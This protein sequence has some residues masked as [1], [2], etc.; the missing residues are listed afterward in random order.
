MCSVVCIGQRT[1]PFVR[2]DHNFVALTLK[3]EKDRSSLSLALPL[4]VV[5]N[6]L[7]LCS[8]VLDAE[9]GPGTS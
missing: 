5:G 4:M 9:M 8:L 6:V 2:K 1:E 3:L 7:C